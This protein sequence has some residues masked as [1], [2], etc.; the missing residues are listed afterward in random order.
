MSPPFLPP[1]HSITDQGYG[2]LPLCDCRALASRPCRRR[3]ASYPT[4]SRRWR[5]AR[6]YGPQPCSVTPACILNLTFATCRSLAATCIWVS[7][8][9]FDHVVLK[10]VGSCPSSVH[11]L[12]SSLIVLWSCR[13]P[14]WREWRRRSPAS[15]RPAPPRHPRP[16]IR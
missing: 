4:T 1:S 3:R 12:P 15:E 5:W 13:W 2:F 10:R 9:S 11:L 14:R 7:V 8:A 6:R 16:N